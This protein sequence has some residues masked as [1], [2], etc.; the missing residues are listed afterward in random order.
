MTEKTPNAES[1]VQAEDER[2][3]I[4]KAIDETEAPTRAE[5]KQPAKKPGVAN[6]PAPGGDRKR[7]EG[8]PPAK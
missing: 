4:R 2:A 1:E 5:V 7:R 6:A 3:A 8:S